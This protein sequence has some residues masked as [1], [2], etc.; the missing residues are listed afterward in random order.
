M[1]LGLRPVS[2]RPARTRHTPAPAPGV[3]IPA[4]AMKPRR[5]GR[6]QRSSGRGSSAR[7]APSDTI[8]AEAWL[9]RHRHWVLLVLVA[10]SIVIRIVYFQQLNADPAIGLH[11]LDQT[12]M[13]YYD[14]L[15]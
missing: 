12:D 4:A 3:P 8:A 10:V 13:N 15:G 2:H 1:A 5:K 9:A 11:R 7:T 6:P 14:A